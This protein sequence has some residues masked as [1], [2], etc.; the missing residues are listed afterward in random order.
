MPDTPA[1]DEHPGAL[2]RA[3]ERLEEHHREHRHEVEER[4]LREDLAAAGY[5]VETDTGIEV[6]RPDGEGADYDVEVDTAEEVRPDRTASPET[7][8]G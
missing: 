2:R 3:V 8:Q 7:G 6:R 5:D 4:R 1:P